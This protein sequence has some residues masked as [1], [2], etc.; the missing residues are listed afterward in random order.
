MFYSLIWST[1]CKRKD[2]SFKTETDKYKLKNILKRPVWNKKPNARVQPGLRGAVTVQSCSGAELTMALFIAETRRGKH[3]RPDLETRRWGE[4]TLFMV[5]RRG[6]PI[7]NKLQQRSVETGLRGTAKPVPPPH[8]AH[9]DQMILSFVIPPF[10]QLPVSAVHPTVNT[11][12]KELLGLCP[13]T[14]NN[15]SFVE[16]MLGYWAVLSW[17][18]APY[19]TYFPTSTYTLGKH[20]LLTASPYLKTTIIL[21]NY[22]KLSTLHTLDNRNTR[23]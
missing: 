15:Y 3:Q 19:T 10:W 23:L 7:T 8:S 22:N 11:S 2:Q 21:N 17:S 14:H 5:P 18:Y 13:M 1:Q 20:C 16:R 9:Q 6:E 4:I 12:W